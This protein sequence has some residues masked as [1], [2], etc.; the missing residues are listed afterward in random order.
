METVIN[1]VATQTDS[2]EESLKKKRSSGFYQIYRKSLFHK[3][4]D[5]IGQ[6]NSKVSTVGRFCLFVQVSLVLYTF[7]Q[8]LRKSN[9]KCK[10]TLIEISQC[11]P[12]SVLVGVRQYS[13]KVMY[14]NHLHQ[15]NWWDH[16]SLQFNEAILPSTNPC[17]HTLS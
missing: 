5:E 11:L 16:C 10:L 4:T 13:I 15:Y 3:G 6:P 8:H 7:L 17:Q 2:V 14:K 12:Q 1:K 9:Y